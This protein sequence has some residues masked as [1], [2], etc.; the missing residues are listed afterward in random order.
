MLLEAGASIEVEIADK[1]NVFH[2]AAKH[3]SEDV[4][5]HL[6]EYNSNITAKLINRFDSMGPPLGYAVLNNHLAC[7]ELLVCKG[8][9]VNAFLECNNIIDRDVVIWTTLLHIAARHNHYEI[10]EMIIKHDSQTV[11]TTDSAGRA[12]LHE[13]CCHGNRE[14][15]VLLLRKGADLSGVGKN[16]FSKTKLPPIDILMNNLSKPTEF[17]QEIFDSYISSQ[18]VNLQDS[19]CEVVVDYGVLVPNK[20]N[21]KR[22]RVI[23]AL[24]NTGNRYDQHRLLLHPLVQ[25]YLYLKW[26]SLLSFFYSILILHVCF[27][28]SLNVY[29]ISVFYYKDTVKTVPIILRSSVWV[30]IIY[31]TVFLI[32]IQVI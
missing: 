11:H 2:V 18:G 12:P 4:L 22:M 24:I 28:V 15:I 1:A 5:Q 23:K 9:Q 13:A 19:N 10:A 21:M 6:L 7:A 27:V 30:Y 31:L 14:M 25:S 20:D 32:T 3:G 16:G 26:K 17:M 29:A 8:A